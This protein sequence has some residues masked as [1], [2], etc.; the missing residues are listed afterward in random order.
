MFDKD[1]DDIQYESIYDMPSRLLYRY[2]TIIRKEPLPNNIPTQIEWYGAWISGNN[3]M[4]DVP[5]DLDDMVSDKYV[6]LLADIF[7]DLGHVYE[8]LQISQCRACKQYRTFH[9]NKR[10]MIGS[11]YFLDMIANTVSLD[12]DIKVNYAIDYMNAYEKALGHTDMDTY[13]E[14]MSELKSE[15]EKMIN[16]KDDG[17]L[18]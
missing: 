7:E 1:L 9:E 15:P 6:Y 12:T 14:R 18:F 10:S 8:E 4:F 11:A 3:Q 13:R 17:P 16:I 2:I 5:L